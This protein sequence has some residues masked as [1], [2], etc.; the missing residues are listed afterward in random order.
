MVFCLVATN[1]YPVGQHACT[2][3]TAEYAS[4]RARERAGLPLRTQNGLR[5]YL[6]VKIDATEA[7]QHLT[8]FRE[9]REEEF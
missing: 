7:L 3:Q 4:N 1:A 8:V 2:R 9:Q 5:P 6:T